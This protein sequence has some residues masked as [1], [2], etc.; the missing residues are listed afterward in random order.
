M[1]A[2][3][4]E[5]HRQSIGN[6]E[7]ILSCAFIQY[8]RIIINNN[9]TT[10]MYEHLQWQWGNIAVCLYGNSVP[11][12]ATGEIIVARIKPKTPDDI[13]TNYDGPSKWTSVLIRS[14]R[15]GRR[16]KI[17]VYCKTGGIS[18]IIGKYFDTKLNMRK[19][20]CRSVGFIDRARWLLFNTKDVEKFPRETMVFISGA[21]MISSHTICTYRS[22]NWVSV[23]LKTKIYENHSET[24]T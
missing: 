14:N 5:F 24:P 1:F 2:R 18:V 13:R 17:L 12:H 6:S 7:T 20:M 9:F 4:T 11:I 15:T 22:N 3:R 19:S 8:E 23:I 21:N 16:M 10:S